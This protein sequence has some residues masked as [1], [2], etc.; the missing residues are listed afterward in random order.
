MFVVVVMDYLKEIIEKFYPEETVLLKKSIKLRNEID[1]S[2]HKHAVHVD[3]RYGKVYAY[4]VD[5]CGKSNF[6][7]DANVPRF[8]FS[9]FFLH[10]YL[11]FFVSP[12]CCQ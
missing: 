2:I 7:D 11:N 3:E 12:V 4:E 6:M 1:E 8:F 5:G 9:F 10:F